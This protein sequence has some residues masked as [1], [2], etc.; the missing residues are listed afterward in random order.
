MN[1]KK[2]GAP[3]DNNATFCGQCG[4]PVEPQINDQMA[5]QQSNMNQPTPDIFQTVEPIQP[6][7]QPIPTVEPIQPEVQPIP[8]VEPV[9]PEVQSVPPVEPMPSIETPS[10]DPISDNEETKKKHSA[11]PIILIVLVLLGIGAFLV[12]K[13]F[14]N[15]P[16]KVVKGLINNAYD[17]FETSLKKYDVKDE[18]VLVNADL[19]INTNIEG[20]E[21]LNGVKF[22]ITS[23][24]DYKNNKFE[25]GLSYLENDNKV[26]DAL[27]YLLDKNAYLVLKDIYTNPI[28]INTEEIKFEEITTEATSVKPED[29]EFLMKR[30]KDIF[31]DSL[32][33]NDFKQSSATITLDGKDTKV[34]KVSYTLDDVKT[35]NLIN[36][37]IDNMS[38]D[39]EFME[40]LASLSNT[41]VETLK[42]ELK[43]SKVDSNSENDETIKFDIYTKGV[44]DDFVGMDIEL[45]NASNI[46]IR[47]NNE[48]TTVEANMSGVL[49]NLTIKEESEEKST[50]DININVLGQEITGQII[51]EE[52]V[53][54]PKTT[55]SKVIFNM[56][57]QEQEIGY[58]LNMKQQLGANIADIDISNAK[59]TEELT[60]E[61]L[62]LI[63][64]KLMEKLAGS[65]LYNFINTQME[66]T[67]DSID[68]KND[69]EYSEYENYDYSL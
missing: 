37:I 13:F 17:K 53:I 24:M 10:F 25:F 31:L 8:T 54:D 49:I 22:N 47:K 62:N 51:S 57:Y 2:C 63:E 67:L 45:S 20:M 43:S 52:K 14:F 36:N 33:M 19:T 50:I 16:D 34:K 59:A 4:T 21:D 65:K 55:E 40:K 6:E 18:S 38:N 56:K 26:L 29:I 35:R 58:T 44:T 27:M 28:K 46:K 61:E 41:D 42:E 48:N 66:K 12:Y 15:K 68:E 60:E 11:L 23:G 64:Q 5:N 7:V 9:Q 3:L 30:F 69:F 1:C 32:N 39:K